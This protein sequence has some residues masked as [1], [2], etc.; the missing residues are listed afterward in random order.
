M[1]DKNNSPVE[2]K[3]LCELYTTKDIIIKTYGNLWT[4]PHH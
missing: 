1:T 4:V 2:K 3:T